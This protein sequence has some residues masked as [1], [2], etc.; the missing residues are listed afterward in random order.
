MNDIASMLGDGYPEGLM[1][2]L[3]NEALPERYAEAHDN[4]STA[5]Q[6]GTPTALTFE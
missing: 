3:A 4:G 2:I 1:K 5:T 6:H